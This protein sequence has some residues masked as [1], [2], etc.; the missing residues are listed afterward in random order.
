MKIDIKKLPKATTELRITLPKEKVDQAFKEAVS[1]LGEGMEIAGFRKGKAPEDVLESK[2]P[3]E[4]LIPTVFEN[5]VPPAVTEAIKEHHLRPI[6]EPRISFT[7]LNK[8]EDFSFTA[9]IVEV[10]TIDCGDYPSALKELGRG[11]KI[12]VARTLSEAEG[13]SKEK[14][15]EEV[16]TTEILATINK[17]G[18]V[19]IADILIG[20]EVKR[21]LSRLVDQTSRLGITVEQYLSSV[22]KSAEDLKR[23]Y[24]KTAEETIKSEFLIVEIAK[25]EAV[26]VE[27]TEIDAMIKASPDE[28]SRAELEKE[29]NRWYIRSIILKTKTLEKLREMCYAGK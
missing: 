24:A 23:D 28:K 1:K 19:E 10:P 20:E 4:K 14:D 6:I 7:T 5:L 25:K 15:Q 9:L 22:G 11:R 27:E 13:K 18:K 21:M 29:E 2:I 8:G 16:G 26:S 17:V 3:E 12:E